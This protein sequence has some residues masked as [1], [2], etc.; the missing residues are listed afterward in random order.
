LSSAFAAIVPLAALARELETAPMEPRTA[1]AAEVRQ[2]ASFWNGREVI[3]VFRAKPTAGAERGS[4]VSADR[5]QLEGV[6]RIEAG[7]FFVGA[8]RL[9]EH[10]EIEEFQLVR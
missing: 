3:A 9:D 6:L 4:P 5:Y 8:D 1:T 10:D 2:D 7:A